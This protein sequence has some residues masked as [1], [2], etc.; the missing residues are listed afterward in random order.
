M[1]KSEKLSKICDAEEPFTVSEAYSISENIHE[2]EEVKDK[3]LKFINTGTI[4][5]YASLWGMKLT[6]YLKTK[7]NK[8]VISEKEMEKNYPRRYSQS[9]DKK[10]IISGI[11]YFESF[12][13][14]NGEWVAGK[15]TVILRNFR[16]DVSPKFLLG[17]LNSRLITFFLRESYGSLSMDG[18]INFSPMNVSEIPISGINNQAKIINLVDRILSTKHT[19]P[20]ENTSSLEA[21]IDQ[22]VYG[23]YE[24][25]EN[26]IKIVEGREG[27]G[28]LVE[29][30]IS[31]PD[32]EEDKVRNA[33]AIESLAEVVPTDYSLYKC[34]E[35][36]K[37]VTD[38][39]IEEHIH[40]S[41]R[42]RQ[43]E[44]KK[45]GG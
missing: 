41:H 24:L 39:M 35:C 33:P 42:G 19:N 10:I 2:E 30:D 32:I 34:G 12:L 23:L 8:P 7:Y 17:L 44:W 6:T 11:R 1:E 13:D 31:N 43:V 38:Y 45:M 29:E 22:L 20:V 3:F 5:S 21:E 37:I 4:D 14:N 9:K 36:G 27:S 26:E 15:S 25:T 28:K 18:G 16:K 40:K